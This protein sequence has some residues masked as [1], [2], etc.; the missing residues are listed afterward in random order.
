VQERINISQGAGAWP[1][2]SRDGRELYIR[3][4][5]EPW[6][7]SRPATG[8]DWPLPRPLFTLDFSADTWHTYDTLPDGRFLAVERVDWDDPRVK[9]VV[10]DAIASFRSNPEPHP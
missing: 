5:D 4:G 9:S 2:W 3:R 8:A 1:R 10:A 7:V 6:A